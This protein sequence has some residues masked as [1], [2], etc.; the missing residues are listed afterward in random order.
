[1]R[2]SFVLIALILFIFGS[3]LYG[4]GN[5]KATNRQ[6]NTGT[7]EESVADASDDTTTGGTM[8]ENPERVVLGGGCFW[9]I[10]AVF[11]MVDGVL[12]ATSGYAGGTTADPTYEEVC[13][14]DTG[15]AEVVSVEYDPRKVSLEELLDIFFASHDPTTTNR[16]GNDVGPQ[17]R[18]IIL[19]DSEEQK[20]RVEDYLEKV[21]GEFDDPVVTELVALGRF[22]PAEEYH[23]DYYEK[24]PS[25]PYCMGVV[26]P[27]VEKVKKM[28]GL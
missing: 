15:H 21:E 24:N 7:E 13:R 2:K 16:Q 17:Y 28:L 19:Y 12:E 27:K 23:Q 22:Y 9:C 8:V 3:C 1:M 20:A 26:E 14:K 11:E 10:E 6:A 4:C 25:K 5:E 18:S